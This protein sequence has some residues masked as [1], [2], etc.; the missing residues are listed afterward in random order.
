VLVASSQWAKLNAKIAKSQDFADLYEASPD[1]ALIF[2][3]SL[4]QAVPWGLLPGNPVLWAALVCPMFGLGKDKAATCLRLIVD[5]GMYTAYLGKDEKPVVFVT[6][7]NDNQDRQWDRCGIPEYDLPPDW[8]PPAGIADG[9]RLAAKSKR[10]LTADG[11]EKRMTSDESKTRLRLVLDESAIRE[12]RGE[13]EENVT[14]PL[15]GVTEPLVPPTHAKPADLHLLPPP[16]PEAPPPQTVADAGNAVLAVWGL[17]Y[18][19]LSNEKPARGKPERAAFFAAI[20][21]LVDDRSVEELVA[22]ADAQGPGTHHLGTGQKAGA[23]IP[24]ELREALTAKGYAKKFAEERD[25]GGG[26]NGQMRVMLSDGTTT[27]EK[28]WADNPWDGDSYEFRQVVARETAA[29]N[30]V[31]GKGITKK[32]TVGL[33]CVDGW[34]YEG[35]FDEAAGGPIPVQKRKVF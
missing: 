16:E 23:A 32:P 31:P 5:S 26:G 28:T 35:K 24:R 1:A 34:Y 21:K 19:D 8:T 10:K 6:A 33:T 22:W 7:W 11:L 9:I 3:M 13:K 12:E 18:Q 14:T 29:G 2:L 30:W 15:R 17:T 25:A 20:G 4:P 27:H